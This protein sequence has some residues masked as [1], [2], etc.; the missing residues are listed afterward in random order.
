MYNNVVFDGSY[1]LHSLEECTRILTSGRIHLQA[2][3]DTGEGHTVFYF[4]V[5]Y[6]DILYC[7]VL[8]ALMY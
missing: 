7:I 3:A 5:L 8:C 2:R 1:R 6:C 4:I